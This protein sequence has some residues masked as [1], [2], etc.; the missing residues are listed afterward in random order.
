VERK[1]TDTKPHRALGRFAAQWPQAQAIQ[2]L[3]DCP[4]E[5]DIGRL[6]VRDAARWLAALP[7]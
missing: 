3:R 5:A 2:L 1:L 4:V 6:Q 7:V